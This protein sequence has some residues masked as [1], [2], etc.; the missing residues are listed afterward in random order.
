MHPNIKELTIT[1]EVWEHQKDDGLWFLRYIEQD[2]D[3]AIRKKAWLK[4]STPDKS[5][6]RVFRIDRI[7]RETIA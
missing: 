3:E 4:S 7:T 2:L 5:F 1:Y 6:S